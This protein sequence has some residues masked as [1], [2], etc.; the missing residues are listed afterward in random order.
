MTSEEISAIAEQLAAILAANDIEYVDWSKMS[1]PEPA[2]PRP[3]CGKL[4]SPTWFKMQAIANKSY[5]GSMAGVIKTAVMVYVRKT[6]VKHCED[7]RAIA[8]QHNLS[9]EECLQ[10]VVSGE[11]KI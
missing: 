5:E 11:L 7:Y 2:N 4:D 8:A 3:Q 10:Q 6:W 1:M 9:L